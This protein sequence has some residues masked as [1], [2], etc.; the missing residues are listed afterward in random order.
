MEKNKIWIR[1]AYDLLSKRTI[2]WKI[3]RRNC[4]T[5]KEFLKETRIK[6]GEFV[7]SHFF[8]RSLRNNTF[9]VK[10]SFPIEQDNSNARHYIGRVRRRPKIT[11]RSLE[12][13]DLYL[14]LLY[15]FQYGSLCQDS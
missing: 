11:S 8:L 10:I 6:N 13:V 12:M 3:G 2:A 15:H 1:K 7:M 9:Q 14:L 4:R 5:L